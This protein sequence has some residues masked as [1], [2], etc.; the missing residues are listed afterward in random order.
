MVLVWGTRCYGQDDGY[1]RHDYCEHCGQ[2][3]RLKTYSTAKFG[4]LYF[5]PIIPLGKKRVFDSCPRCEMQREAPLAAYNKGKE[6]DLAEMYEVL[7]GQGQAPELVTKGIMM[8]LAYGQFDHFKAAAP[9]L[10]KEYS[11][12]HEVLGALA[13][14]Y[15]YL[16][17]LESA[18]RLYLQCLALEESNEDEGEETRVALAANRIHQLKLD[19]V[20]DLLQTILTKGNKERVGIFYFLVEGLLHTARHDEALAV[21]SDIEALDES[22]AEDEDHQNYIKKAEAGRVSQLEQS[23]A[24]IGKKRGVEPLGKGVPLWLPGMLPLT[25]ILFVVGSYLLTAIGLGAGQTVWLVNG[26]NHDYTVTINGQDYLARA[27]NRKE[28]KLPEGTLNYVI[29]DSAFPALPQSSQFSTEFF[30]RPFNDVVFV[31]NPDK[32]ALLGIQTTTYAQAGSSPVEDHMDWRSGQSFYE[33]DNIDFPFREFPSSLSLDSRNSRVRKTRVSQVKPKTFIERFSI[34][35][36]ALKD[37]GDAFQKYLQLYVLMEPDDFQALQVLSSYY[38]P[39]KLADFN[40][41]LEPGL[42]KRPLL[43]QWH[44]LFQETV[45]RFDPERDLEKEYRDLVAKE[46]G[47]SLLKYLLGRITKTP[48]VSEKLFL[49]SEKGAKPIGYGWNAIAYNK[50]CAGQFKEALELSKRARGVLPKS[51]SFT[52]NVKNCALAAGLYGEFLEVLS[53]EKSLSPLRKDLARYELMAL[54]LL[55]REGEAK[56]ALGAYMRSIKGRTESDADW[57]AIQ[58]ELE[59]ALSYVGGDFKRF[60]DLMEKARIADPFQTKILWGQLAEAYEILKTS[61]STDFRLFLIFYCAAKGTQGFEKEGEQS[62]ARAI[63]LLQMGSYEMRMAAEMLAGKEELVKQQ[64]ESF[65][66]SSDY[67]SI[68]ALSLSHRYPKQR[69]LCRT[70]AKAHNYH[71]DF[72]RLII[73]QL[74]K[75]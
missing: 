55:G 28:L 46:P 62:L 71:L 23:S 45:E 59:A 41:F 6:S 61:K 8:L 21:L 65:S 57:K 31:L 26:T 20:R 58:I 64:L 39:D 13:A 34:A 38:L 53:A 49:E 11:R 7:K 69:V 17:D 68:V 43:V 63:E 4:H 27:N 75:K 56:K 1:S 66:L 10:E 29:K 74:L 3:G 60:L 24:L 54:A 30:S 2:H 72:P 37:K 40:K 9:V 22:V 5:I 14:I 25:A 18:E 73:Q 16:G 32:V 70:V 48:G 36:H 42:K 67:K 51:L 19:G 47:N 15:D 52:D 12:E 33:L 50:L 35:S 44:R